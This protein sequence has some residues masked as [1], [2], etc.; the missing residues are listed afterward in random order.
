M[1]LLPIIIV[2]SL[3]AFFI[4]LMIVMLVWQYTKSSTRRKSDRN[5]E[6]ID[7][8]TRQLTVRSGR[9]V[10]LSEALHG[11]DVDGF[12]SAD[13]SSLRSGGSTH[14]LHE[15]ELQYPA[16][17]YKSDRWHS[18]PPVDLEAQHYQREREQI[19]EKVLRT[20]SESQ[21][22]SPKTLPKPRK[23]RDINEERQASITES[24]LKAYKG[25]PIPGTEPVELPASP[26]S[27]PIIVRKLS[28]K[29]H[30][31]PDQIKPSRPRRKEWKSNTA[32]PDQT[33]SPSPRKKER[34]SKSTGRSRTLANKTVT[35]QSPDRRRHSEGDRKT[36][37]LDDIQLPTPR[38][39]G[40]QDSFRKSVEEH[41][42]SVSFF[43]NSPSSSIV[44]QPI[45]P[46][47]IPTRKPA[48]PHRLSEATTKSL[49]VNSKEDEGNISPIRKKNRPPDINT[50]IP[51]QRESWFIDSLS[52]TKTSKDIN[53]GPSV[54]SNRSDTTYNSSEIP[55]ATNWTFGNAR[56][57]SI[58]PSVVPQ[59]LSMP[60]VQRPKSKY[61]RRVK[62]PRDKRL[63]VLPK[64]P[65]SQ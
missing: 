44:S 20:L 25:P 33:D 14:T 65:L 16:P 3:L 46:L 10:P 27:T 30:S 22:P 61:R 38:F 39:T 52:S 55:T 47:A 17:L 19:S 11:R 15:K 4:A 7:R 51:N 37:L 42:F 2:V 8:P 23:L 12:N 48:T 28:Q 5:R 9:V 36:S 54:M 50:K 18:S 31:S 24:L 59:K 64:S 43:S 26:L 32:S 62:T 41:E 13:L 49:K 57:L 53:R 58:A 45:D 34:R 60:P 56:A 40:N 35:F 1:K 29:G 21:P 6:S 63:P